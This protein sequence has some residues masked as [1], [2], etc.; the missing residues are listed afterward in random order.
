[1]TG[2]YK[3][4]VRGSALTVLQSMGI[5][6]KVLAASTDMQGAILVDSKGGVLSEMSGDAFG[7][8]QG[9]DLEITR[10]RLCQILMDQIPDVEIIFGDTI[11]GISERA[12]SVLVTFKE[13]PAR[14][15]D[16]V[17]GADGLHCA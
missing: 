4:D 15:F 8:R 1:L 5:Y 12:N 6:E 2:G 11:E 14:E 3:I 9:D 10:G 7:H 13:N 16:L 17:I